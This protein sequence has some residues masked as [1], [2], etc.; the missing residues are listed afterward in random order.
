MKRFLNSLFRRSRMDAEIAEE[1]QS[2]LAMRADLERQSGLDAAEAQV[3]AR[4]KF[5]N[6]TLILEDTRQ[7]HLRPFFES[8]LQDLS[9]ALRQLRRNPAFSI[10]VLFILALGIGAS[11][12][13][14]TVVDGVLFR[15]APYTDP[16]RIVAYGITA[17]IETREFLFGSGYLYWQGKIPAF[18]AVTSMFPGDQGCDL[19]ETNPARLACV[20]IES[21]LLPMFGVRPVIGRNFMRDEDRPHTPHVA[22]LSYNFWQTRYG[23]QPTVL[24]LRISLDNTP[25]KI[26][27]VLPR[28]FVLPT[29]GRFDVLLPEQQDEAGPMFTINNATLRTFARLRP[30]WT[31]AQ[32]ASALQPML[33]QTIS[34]APPA[35]RKEIHIGVHTIRDWQNGDRRQTSWVLL[36][37]VLAVLML[38]CMNVASLLLARATS[39]QR[40]LAMRQALGASRSRLV[41]HAI[42]ESLLL[43]C[44]G[45]ALGC[46]LSFFLLKILLIA[47]PNSIPGLTEVHFSVRIFVIAGLLSLLSGL[48]FGALPAL[49]QPTLE[50][51]TGW[52]ATSPSK[53]SI[54]D[55]LVTCQIAGSLIMLTAA[56][57]MLRTL[58]NL[59][60]VSLGVDAE[61]VVTAQFTLGRSYDFTRLMVFSETLEQR[62][63]H[64]PGVNSVALADTIPPGGLTRSMPFFAVRVIGRAPSEQGVGGMLPWRAVS[65]DYFRTFHVRLLQGRAFDASDM[66]TGS[67]LAMVLSQ[68]LAHKLFPA[69]N[70][71]GHR[72]TLGESDRGI[73]TEAYSVVGVAGDVRNS[74]LAGAPDPEFYLDRDQFPTLW[75]HG[76]TNHHIAVAIRS[77][78]RSQFLESWLRDEIH[79]LDPS[80]PVDVM[81]MQDRV[82]DFA[83][84]ERFHA[85]LFSLFA[86][87][88]LLLAVSGLYGLVRFLVARRTQEIGVRIALGASPAGIATMIVGSAL[89]FTLAGAALG[90]AGALLVSRWLESMLYQ[91]PSRDPLTITIVAAVLVVCGIAA[92]LAPSLTAARTD[93]MTALRTD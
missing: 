11:T 31:L 65:S 21:T 87:I 68:S 53:T 77:N 4:R 34:G 75:F 67:A 19:T 41:R 27:G 14:F 2:H 54:R 66:S 73:A 58:S 12:A 72:V 42:T 79:A 29:L 45:G 46:A 82:R 60:N 33:K 50:I 51:F 89:R 8:I 83:V 39:R 36:L 49:R 86:A 20:R 70:P 35:Y 55:A 40:E 59:E 91:T 85:I 52:R 38:A 69:E 62:L 3:S 48:V 15:P 61:H 28:D 56:G 37:A 76:P 80:V 32:A 47:S 1:L 23:G 43:S 30:G 81:T 90:I 93:P 6:A 17:P 92:A 18:E 63:R 7:F 84:P 24:G 5:G 74:G 88:T 9:H 57:L 71:I 13:V 25:A 22:L 44:C 64:Q 78:L 16:D 26:I 10:T